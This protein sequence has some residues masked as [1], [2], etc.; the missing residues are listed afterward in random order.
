ML[1][2]LVDE[3]TRIQFDFVD[4]WHTF[5]HTL[6][7]FFY[8]DMMM[9]VGGVMILDDVGYPGLKRL[10]EFIVSNRAYS[11]LDGA[12]RLTSDDWKS[13][14][15]SLARKA[16]NRFVRDDMT[17]SLETRSIQES[18]GRCQLVALRKTAN[19]NR[20]FDHFVPF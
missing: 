5:D 18:V 14:A 10:A 13:S 12:P 15:K 11:Y 1:P 9:D 2:K 3:G 4:G 20:R 16:L 8:L 7:D 17:P 6:V 19:D